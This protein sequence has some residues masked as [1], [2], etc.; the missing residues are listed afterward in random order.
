VHSRYKWLVVAMLWWISFFN[1][2]DRQAIFSVF[3]VLDKEMH[4]QVG[5]RGLLGSSFALVYGLSAPAAGFIIDRVRR[6]TAILGGLQVWSLICMATAWS[7]NLR[8]LLFFRAAEGLGESFYYPASVSMLSDYH[9]TTTRSRALGI[10]QTSVYLGTIGGGFFAGWIGE[11]YGW[12]WSF[13]VFGGAGI[14]LGIILQRFLREPVR[15]AS[16]LPSD[17]LKDE[18][19]ENDIDRDESS[20]MSQVG[21][22]ESSEPTAATSSSVAFEGSSPPTT[23]RLSVRQIGILIW[24]RPTVMLL[25]MA[26]ICANYVAMVLLSWMPTYLHSF[27]LTLAWAGLAATVFAQLASMVGAFIGGWLADI[28]RMRMAAGRVF[29]QASGVLLGAP[30]VFLCGQTQSLLMVALAL[31]AWG[32]FKGLYDANIF[33]SVFDVVEPEA[34]GTLAGLMNMVGWVGG[35]AV[36]PLVVDYL[37]AYYGLGPAIS[38]AASVYLAAGGCLVLAGGIFIRRDIVRMQTDSI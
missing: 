19:T 25:M 38:S 6:K 22:V 29:V 28:L 12:R 31:T 15:G 4:F 21:C 24:N 10:H 34:R 20:S 32:L 3:D 9:G 11:R 14:L 35:G 30:F 27:G 36:A 17:S 8:Q 2:A 23:K 18:G 33:A 26:F 16:E 1:Y 7:R 5:D 37:S 13:A